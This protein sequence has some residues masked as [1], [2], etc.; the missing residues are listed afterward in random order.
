MSNRTFQEKVKDIVGAI[1]FLQAAGFDREELSIQDR[2]EEY[3]VF[4]LERITDIEYLR[5]R[6]ILSLDWCLFPGLIIVFL[7]ILI[8]ALENAERI[9]LEL[10]RNVQILQPAQAER[11]TQL[12]DDFYRYTPEELKKEHQ[13]R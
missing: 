11:R 2:T 3:L 7:Q 12:P 1:E 4:S 5:V 10:D 8:D 6:N 13:S 9:E